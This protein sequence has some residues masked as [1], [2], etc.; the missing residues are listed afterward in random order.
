MRIA[1]LNSWPNLEYSAER[2]FIARLKLACLNLNWVCIEVVTSEDVL[3]ANADCVIVTHEFSPKLTEIP[4][5][6][7]PLEPSRFLSA[8]LRS[9]TKYSQL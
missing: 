7:P 5:I 3:S 6:R 2:E 4:T 8:R 9:D 1:V